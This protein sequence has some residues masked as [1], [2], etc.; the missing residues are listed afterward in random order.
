IERSEKTNR[1]IKRNAGKDNENVKH[2]PSLVK[3]INKCIFP[4][5]A[6][7]LEI[8]HSNSVI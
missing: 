4:N 1:V 3:E 5:F 8:L 7:A 2:D 6:N